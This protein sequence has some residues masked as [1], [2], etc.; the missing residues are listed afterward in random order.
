MPPGLTISLPPGSRTVRN[1]SCPFLTCK[2][3][4][5]KRVHYLILDLEKSLEYYGEN[6]RK[7]SER[8]QTQ[9]KHALSLLFVKK[10]YQQ[11]VGK[12]EGISLKLSRYV[13]V[14]FKRD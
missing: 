13:K 11:Y 9:S 7:F 10:E 12:A 4:Y 2:V 6:L 1:A 5:Q 8:C 3:F 14:M